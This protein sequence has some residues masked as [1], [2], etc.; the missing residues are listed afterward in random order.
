M[1]SQ[2]PVIDISEAA[3][4]HTHQAIDAACREWGVFQVVGH[5]VDLRLM[6][7]LRRQMRSL[8]GAPLEE[9]LAIARTASNPWGFYDRELTRHERDWKQV[10]DY[11]PPDGA[12]IAPQWPSGLPAFQPGK[13]STLPSPWKPRSRA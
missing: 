4:A 8:F 11:G 2:I 9:K 10:Y 3:R 13:I 1:A 6:A 12:E 7:A 5:G